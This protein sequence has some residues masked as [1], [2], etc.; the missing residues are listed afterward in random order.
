MQWGVHFCVHL[1][2]FLCTPV[3]IFVYTWRY[4]NYTQIRKRWHPLWGATLLNINLISLLVL[5]QAKLNRK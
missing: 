3:Y 4:R 5:L 2:T 1:S